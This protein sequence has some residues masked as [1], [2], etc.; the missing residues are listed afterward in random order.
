MR[1]ASGCTIGTTS[2]NS[3]ASV[4]GCSFRSS[5]RVNFRNPCTTSSSRRISFA[6]TSTCWSASVESIGGAAATASP[7]PAPPRR[8]AAPIARDGELLPQQLEVNHHRVQRILHLVR[9][10]GR[11]PSERGQ[12]ARVANR[13]LHLAQYSRL[14]AI[15]MMPTSS[16]LGSLI[17]CV[18]TSRS[19]PV[20]ER[21]RQRTA[22]LAA[23][24][25]L[26]GQP[27]QRVVG[28][29]DR[30]SAAPAGAPAAARASPGWRT[31]AR[32]AR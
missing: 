17:A 2:S 31:A 21:R 11:Q 1:S 14:R 24:E 15:S 32:R 29:H 23:D 27:P 4:T 20:A 10:A 19:P 22:R 18:I 26:L 16:P 12:L 9:D 30:R 28:R 13:R 8:R 5:G 3:A 6:M 25:R 7:R